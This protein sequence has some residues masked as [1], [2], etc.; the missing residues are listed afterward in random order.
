MIVETKG[1]W[2]ATPHIF[3]PCQLWEE[4]LRGLRLQ[5]QCSKNCEAIISPIEDVDFAIT[6]YG[7]SMAP[8]YPLRFPYFDKEDKPPIFL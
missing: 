7:D 1:I 8:E 4:R 6:V 3:F 2:E 5:A